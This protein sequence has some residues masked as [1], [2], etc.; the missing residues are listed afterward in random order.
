MAGSVRV[1]L[2]QGAV[3][4]ILQSSDVLADLTRRAQAIAAAAGEGM[5]VDSGIGRNRARASVRTHTHA[6]V[7]AESQD[8]ALTSAIGAGR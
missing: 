5:E 2:N 4:A 3:R 8:K 1:T 6:A 7:V